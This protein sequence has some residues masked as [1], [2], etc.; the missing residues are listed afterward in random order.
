ML[1]AEDAVASANDFVYA[2]ARQQF[3]DL[4][5]KGENRRHESVEDGRSAGDRQDESARNHEK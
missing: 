5:R 3:V 2:I 4:D 1:F